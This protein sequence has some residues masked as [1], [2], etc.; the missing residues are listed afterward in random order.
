MPVE[1]VFTRSLR[2]SLSPKYVRR[3]PARSFHS[4][5]LCSF[6]WSQRFSQAVKSSSRM[7]SDATQPIRCFTCIGSRRTSYPAT[8]ASPSVMSVKPVSSLIIVVLPAPCGPRSPKT[9][10]SATFRLTWST[11]LSFPY[12]FVR[13]SVTMALAAM[14]HLPSLRKDP[15][16]LFAHLDHDPTELVRLLRG[17]LVHVRAEELARRPEL[18]EERGPLWPDRGLEGAETLLDLR[19]AAP[20]LR[21][22]FAGDSVRLA[23]FLAAHGQVS[24]AEEGPPGG[25]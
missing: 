16:R 9:V 15:H 12:T 4:G 14:E 19:S 24:F 6:A 11:A 22:H 21:L 25:I 3:S 17:D 10:P 1:K 20:Q 18:P 2:R 5:R 8:H 23:P 7:T 13:F